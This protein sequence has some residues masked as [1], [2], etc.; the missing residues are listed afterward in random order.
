MAELADGTYT[1]PELDPWRKDRDGD[2]IGIWRPGDPRGLRPT[3]VEDCAYAV[4]LPHSCEEWVIAECV[5]RDE[6]VRQLDRFI[7]A[8]T[9]VRE[10]LADE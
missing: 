5:D 9:R 4:F 6:A 3:D 8:L 10:E 7:G 1:A 2:H